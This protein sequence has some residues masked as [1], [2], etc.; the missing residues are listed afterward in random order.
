MAP[1]EARIDVRAEARDRARVVRLMIFDVDGVLT[2]GTLYYGP[3]GEALKVF[4]ILDGH[5]LKMLGASGVRTA[6]LSGR[7]SPTV[8]RRAA[9]LGIEIVL[10]GIDDKR[11][12]FDTLVARLGIATAQCGFMG[13]DLPDLPVLSRCGFAVSV[14]NA[15]DAVRS[16][17]HYV[18]RVA[19]GRGA[20]REICEF[21][22]EAQGT[23]AAALAPYTT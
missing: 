15:P 12:A 21:I 1:T 10:Q 20:A 17:V 3:D 4:N 2:D 7:R 16:R 18:T 13:D 5:G 9:E 14:P 8:E 19:G 6:I 22:M 23:L 11:A